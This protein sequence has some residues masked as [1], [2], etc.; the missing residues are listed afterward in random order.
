[1]VFDAGPGLSYDAV[2]ERVRARLHLIPR[3]RQRLRS[4]AP[5]AGQP[6]C[7]STTPTSTSAG[8]C[9]ARRCPTPGGDERLGELVGHEMSRRLDRDAAAVG[10]DDRRGARRRAGRRCWP[11]C[12][13][14]SS[15]AWRRSTSG[16]CCS[17]RR[18]SRSTCPRPS[19]GSPSAYDRAPPP[20]PAA[21]AR[22]SARSGC[23]GR[24]GCARC[25][26]RRARRRSCGAPPTTCCGR[27][28]CSS[29]SRARGRRRRSRRST[30][31]SGPTAGTRRGGSTWR[32]SR[33]WPSRARRRS[34]TRS[35]PSSAGCCA[36]TW[37]AAG[38]PLEP[39]PVALVPVS[40]RQPG[41][42]ARQPD[43]DRP[44]SS[45]RSPRPTRRRASTRCA[46]RMRALKDSA[47]VRAGALLVGATGWA[48]PIMSNALARAMGGV[49]AFNLVVSNV[50]GPAAAVLPQRRA[51][52]RG[53]SRR[54]AQPGQPGAD[55]RGPQLRRRRPL[56]PAGRPRP[57]A[58][59]RPRPRR[60]SPTRPRSCWRQARPLPACA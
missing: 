20:A 51:A 38:E 10:A 2:V 35:S 46:R 5:G 55:R 50:P 42:G 60:P 24:A 47:A 29:S 4:P 16:R 57:A 18:R 59:A 48:P 34:T 17:T 37:S 14:R 22:S 40:V 12:T 21:L 11:R 28:S 32:R 53:L 26:T 49:R 56:R 27:P 13:T 8:T 45:S 19:R 25:A 58:A 33:R 39:S 9:A 52:A 30:A 15:T 54:A 23:R 3:Y 31:A 6:R 43:L 7:G 41:D 44:R 36:A 1:M